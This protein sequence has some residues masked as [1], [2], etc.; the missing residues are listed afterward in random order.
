M[1]L[2]GMDAAEGLRFI[3]VEA[4]DKNSIDIQLSN[5]N[6]VILETRF[7]LE[8]PGFAELAQDDRI[9]YPKTEGETIFWHGGPRPLTV[10]EVIALVGKADCVEKQL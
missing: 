8:L 4:A 10:Q 5:G 9:L 3:R 1:V 7:I 2:S 6:I